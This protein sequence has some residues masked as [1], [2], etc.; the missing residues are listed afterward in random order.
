MAELYYTDTVKCELGRDSNCTMKDKLRLGPHCAKC[1]F[2]S[3][4]HRARLNLLKENG[5]TVFENGLKG[6]R[7]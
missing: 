6:L 5:M 2:N 4:V 7:L 3:K 1:G